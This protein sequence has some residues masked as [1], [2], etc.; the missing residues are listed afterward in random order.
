MVYRSKSEWASWF[1]QGAVHITDVAKAVVLSCSALLK[2]NAPFHEVIEID[3]KHDFSEE[4]RTRWSC[5]GTKAFLCERYPEFRSLIQATTCL[6][7]VP[8]SYKDT[9]RAESLIGYEPLYG[10]RELLAEL[11]TEQF[12]SDAGQRT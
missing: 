5:L 4:D 7:D 10:Y 12:V 2:A 1:A 9:S 8:P 11:E 6:P 3:G